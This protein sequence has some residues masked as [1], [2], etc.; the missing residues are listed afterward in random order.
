LVSR[1]L[2]KYSDRRHSIP[3]HAELEYPKDSITFGH[4]I[5]IPEEACTADCRLVEYLLDLSCLNPSV[6]SNPE[7]STCVSD[8]LPKKRGLYTLS[9]K[10][11]LRRIF[12]LQQCLRAS[13]SSCLSILTSLSV[14]LVLDVVTNAPSEKPFLQSADSL[15]QLS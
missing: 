12:I 8:F 3:S 2:Y 9:L 13:N 4:A 11:L 1:A 6:R 15:Q 5:K 7:D 10:R 14:V